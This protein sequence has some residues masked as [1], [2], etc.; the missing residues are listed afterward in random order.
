MAGALA[1]AG[2]AEEETAILKPKTVG[3]SASGS[4]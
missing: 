1:E 4:D 3:A 2:A